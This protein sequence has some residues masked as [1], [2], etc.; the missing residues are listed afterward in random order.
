MNQ[1]Q[2]NRQGAYII[3]EALVMVTTV[4]ISLSLG[5][6]IHQYFAILPPSLYGML[7]FAL[8]L[9]VGNATQLMPEKLFHR[10]MSFVLRYLSFVFVPV[11]VGV[12]QY[13]DLLLQSGVK[14]ILIG[15]VTTLCVISLVAWLA[16]RLLHE[17]SRD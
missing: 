3:F 13:G 15:S 4:A 12:M 1:S 7:I 11:S 6:L 14:I 10:P 9:S 8:F 17:P 16:K 5:K 2:R